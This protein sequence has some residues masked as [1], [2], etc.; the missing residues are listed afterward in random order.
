MKKTILILLLL[1]LYRIIPGRP[2][3]F[4][5]QIAIALFCGSIFMDKKIAFLIPLMCMFIS[6]ILYQVLYTYNL[7]TIQGFYDGQILN[8]ALLTSL[9][10]F[11]FY[12]KKNPIISII[13]A[14]TAYF[15]V[16]NFLV[17]ISNG[18]LH[19]TNIIQCYVDAIPFYAMSL[20]STALFSTLFMI[21]NIKI[22]ESSKN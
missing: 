18:G 10:F 13:S 17:Y 6:D 5:P 1:I 3:G 2:M 19:R 14:P 12:L 8:Y 4:S 11:G 7:S 15:I 16:S 22:Y 9:V 20:L 21:S